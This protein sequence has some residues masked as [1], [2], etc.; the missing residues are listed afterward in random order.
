MTRILARRLVAWGLVAVG[1][2]VAAVAVWPRAD[3]EP[4]A[5]GSRTAQAGDVAVTMTAL[6]L[7][8]DGAAFDI[9]LET[10]SVEL[11]IDLAEAGQLSIDGQ[12]ADRG[13][14]LGSA[15]G[16][17]HR[18]GTLSFPTAVPSGAR[19]ELLING[20]PQEVSGLWTAP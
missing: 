18:S 10:H 14:W 11:D 5:L 1:L 19:V 13:T 16:G 17:H 15:P 3:T 7:G 12:L 9:A 6:S 8:P 2:G 20:L 4:E